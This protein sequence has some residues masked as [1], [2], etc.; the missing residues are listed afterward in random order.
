M[1]TQTFQHHYHENLPPHPVDKETKLVSLLFL[2]TSKTAE[3]LSKNENWFIKLPKN[4][5]VVVFSDRPHRIAKRIPSIENF[6]KFFLDSDLTTDPPNVTIAGNLN[7]DSKEYYSIVEIGSPTID[8]DDILLPIMKPIG[9]EKIIPEGSYSDLSLVVDSVWGWIWGGLE[10]AGAAAVTGVACTVGEVATLG[11]DT[12]ICVGG[13]AGT[14]GLTGNV[15][16]NNT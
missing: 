13:V 3:I 7:T 15:V 1:D 16:N 14:V 10:V 11:A 12:A 5:N 6:A 9:E 8:G 2:I 4:A